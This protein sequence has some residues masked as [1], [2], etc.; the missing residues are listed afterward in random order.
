MLAVRSSAVS[1]P[2]SQLSGPTQGFLRVH[3][4]NIRI[5]GGD[6]LEAARWSLTAP[7]GRRENG[8]CLTARRRG[9][10]DRHLTSLRDR[11]CKIGG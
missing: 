7:S 3:V 1:Q 11:C 6:A 10:L 9:S 4:S 2:G 8:A 5:E